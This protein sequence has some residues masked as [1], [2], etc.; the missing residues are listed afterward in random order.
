VLPRPINVNWETILSTTSARTFRPDIQGLRAIAV[1]LVLVY[2]A[3]IAVVPGGYIGVDIFLVVS[4]FLIT[5]HLLNQ[6]E[7]NSRIDFVNFYAR[8][9]RRI[10][11]ASMV[12]LVLTVLGAIALVPPLQRVAVMQDA[13]A[14]ALYVPNYWFAIQGTNYL[15]SEAP[16]MFQHYWSL[17]IEE[18]FYL[19]WPALLALG[20]FLVRRSK[21]GLFILMA[22]L[23]VA[24]FAFS[25]WQL[26]QS[27]PWA[28]F[29][30]P[31][32]AWELGVGGLVAFALSKGARWAQGAPVAILGWV[33]LL[34]LLALAA[35]Y[36]ESTVFPGVNA[37]LPVLA[38]A[39]LIIGGTAGHA[40]SPARTL[41]IAPLQWFGMI[42]YS[43]YLVHWPILMLAQAA[44]GLQEPLLLTSKIGLAL[45]AIPV[46]YFLY[47]LVENPARTAEFWAKARPRRTLVSG[48]I[49]SVAVLGLSA[50]SLAVISTSTLSTNRTAASS[51]ASLKP[52]GTAYVPSNLKPSLQDADSDNPVIYANGCHREFDSV[53]AAGCLVGTNPSA[54]I[55]ALF[56]DSHA[57][58]WY[59]AL[60]VM[61]EA[62]EIRLDV[63][64]KSSCP[65]VSID[66]RRDGSLYT[67]CTR[68]RA[69]VIERLTAEAP[70]VVLLA[71]YGRAD[72]GGS[73]DRFAESWG[74]GLQTTIEALAPSKVAILSDTPDMGS[75]PAICLS[76]HLEDATKCARPANEAINKDVRTVEQAEK[77]AK[78][79]DF[80]GYFCDERT[81]PAVIGSTLVYRD[82]HH[83]TAT[84][85]AGLADVVGAQVKKLIA[86]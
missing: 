61:A 49:A 30:L 77:G 5:G 26:Q 18:Q 7:R 42:S 63:N 3:G 19:F 56:G 74:K 24:S 22:V 45:F 85:S 46:A 37:L 62:G 59:P 34:G 67:E 81:C 66:V 80:I 79:L 70:A 73:P 14:T 20:Y 51:E 60:A 27:Q 11:P 75:P 28:F 17:G 16:S 53:D 39:A 86:G 58:Q 41:S 72:I 68:W 43:L 10:L 6:L 84:F 54:P 76:S 38:T 1:L 65:S 15:A 29:S 64:T 36:N 44:I 33:G 32:R 12:V 82:S 69:A 31:S 57:A 4:G 2:H 25:V 47:L 13:L 71:N 78:Y 83:M 8:R 21:R 35:T 9:I 55:V 40:L 23:V 50:G 48:L 52:L